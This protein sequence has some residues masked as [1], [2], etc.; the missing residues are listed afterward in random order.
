MRCTGFKIAQV[1][2]FP[3]QI[4]SDTLMRNLL[5]PLLPHSVLTGPTVCEDHR[6]CLFTRVTW[7]PTGRCPTLWSTEGRLIAGILGIICLVLMS[8]VV[9]IAVIPSYHCC[10]KEWLTCDNNC[11]YIS[12][13]RKSWHESSESCASKNSNLL[14]IDD[15][16]EMCLLYVFIHSSWIKV[17][18]RSHYNSSV[19]PKGSSF[20]SKGLS[21]SSESDKDCPFFN[22]D[23]RKCSFD[24]CLERK[25]YVCKH[26]AY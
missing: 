26:Q 16:E 25:T 7:S 2:E 22:F 17:C 9:R 19:W 14:S 13:E 12:T 5:F 6:H 24:S 23:S 4:L 3:V 21:I 8:T 11:Y 1:S 20:F 15:E 18:Q 10:P